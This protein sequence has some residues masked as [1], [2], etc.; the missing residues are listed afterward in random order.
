MPASL[1][2]THDPKRRSFVESAN[3]PGGDFPI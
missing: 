1:N 2:E 3:A